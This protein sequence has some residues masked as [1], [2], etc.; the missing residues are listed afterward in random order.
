MNSQIILLNNILI[1]S[2][3]TNEFNMIQKKASG[4]IGGGESGNL[5]RWFQSTH[6]KS[7]QRISNR[8]QKNNN[9]RHQTYCRKQWKNSEIKVCTSAEIDK[10]N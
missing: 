1:L 7:N 8:D 3:L 9:M 5:M 6:G 2:M 4:F 10:N